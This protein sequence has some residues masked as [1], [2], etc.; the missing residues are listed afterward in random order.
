MAQFNPRLSRGKCDTEYRKASSVCPER[1][2]PLASVIVNES[3][4]GIDFFLLSNSK[5]TALNAALA[6][7]VSKTVSR[8]NTSTPASKRTSAC[9]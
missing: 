7:K 9:S 5:L 2:L 4:T 3:I 6:F 1:V 8:R